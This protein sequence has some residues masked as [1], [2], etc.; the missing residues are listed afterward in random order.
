MNIALQGGGAH[1]AF[2]WGVLDKLLE[3]GRLAFDGIC[4]CSAG[5]MNACAMAYGMHL[6]GPEKARECLHDFWYNIHRAGRSPWDDV[7]FAR[8]NQ[9]LR[10]FLFDSMTR[11]FSPYQFNP[12][13]IN[14]LRDVLA[15]SIDFKA[16]RECDCVKLFVSATNVRTGKVKVF[17]A[18]ELTL[19]VVMAS[20][21]LPFLFKAVEIDGENYWDGGYMGNP[22][23]FPLFYKTDSRDIVI[24]QINPIERNVLPTT[25]PDIMNRIN[26]ISFNSSLLKDM[27]AIAFV[28]KLIEHEM[29]KDE[30]KKD[31][32]D[33]LLHSIRADQATCGLSISS[34]TDTGWKFLTHLRDQGREMAEQWLQ[35]NFDKIGVS[36]TVDLHTE[37]LDSVT[38]LFDKQEARHSTGA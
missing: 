38:D 26:E 14:P 27:R 30:H 11:L 25:A 24:I 21:C 37:F 19:D 16:L 12:F 29:I 8:L 10:Y 15:K 36:D 23:M 28:K 22:S 3:D 6:G 35:E 5:T 34:K 13:D 1:G 17:E 4:S 33:V 32:K 20:A 9:S 2:A 31:F 18:H 7:P